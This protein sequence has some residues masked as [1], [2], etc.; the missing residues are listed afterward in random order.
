M[1]KVLVTGSTGFIGKRLIHQLIDQGHEVYA[2]SR[3][4]GIEVKISGAHRLHTIY[5]DI[6]N[7]VQAP[8]LPQDIDVAYYLIHSMASVVENLVEVEKDIAAEFINLIE[9]TRCKQIIYLGGIVEDEI[10]LSPHLRSRLAVEKEL[11]KSKIPVTIFRASIIIGAG[12]ASFEIIRDL[13]EKLPIMVAPRWVRNFCQ[14]ISIRDV[15][16]YLEAV[17]LQEEC[18]LQTFDLGGPEAISF[19][20]VMKRYAAFRKIK[21]W[22]INVPVL[23]PRLSSYWLVFVTSVRFSICWH[24]VESMKQSTRKLNLAIDEVLPHK[25]LSYEEALDLTFQKISQNEVVS[26]WMDAW[27][28]GKSLAACIEVPQKGCLKDIQRV[29][30]KQSVEQVH[31][32]VWSIGGERGWYS[33][34]WAWRLR[35]LMDQ[36][37]GGTGFNRGRRHPSQITVGESID[38]WRVILA[39]EKNHHLILFA[40]MKIPGEAWLEFQIDEASKTLMQTA[41]FRPRGFF[42]RLYW[43]CFLPFHLI[44]FKNIAKAVARATESRS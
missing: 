16:Y 38:F 4:E 34:N 7:P 41:T 32:T 26:T 31:K 20:E 30:L 42:G 43:Y 33:M 9:K 21:R 19:E 22:I 15:L 13:T 36:M 24:L 28:Y 35:G 12:S 2:L 27:E 1:A 40:E 10:K 39:D 25:C 8:Q 3:F 17:L 6:G 37:V 18:Y 14:P 23:T 5:G 11:W 44:I 29:P